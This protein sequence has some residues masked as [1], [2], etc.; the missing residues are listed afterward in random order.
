[1]AD[2]HVGVKTTNG[3][4]L[5]LF[6]MGFTTKCNSQIQKTSMHGINKSA[7]SGRRQWKP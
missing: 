5:H 3:Y 6:C 4:F 7:K 2:G 1:M